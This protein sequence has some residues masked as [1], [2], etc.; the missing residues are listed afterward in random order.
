MILPLHGTPQERA[1]YRIKNKQFYGFTG[2]Y[3][4][5]RTIDPLLE[6]PL[7]VVAD[8]DKSD[9]S[10]KPVIIAYCCNEALARD[11]AIQLAKLHDSEVPS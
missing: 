3:Q 4:T 10:G 8:N 6:I 2:R 9:L 5:Y 1:S 7:W 11:T